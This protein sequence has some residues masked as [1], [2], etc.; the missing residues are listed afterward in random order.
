[1]E[2]ALVLASMRISMIIRIAI[3]G[4]MDMGDIADKVALPR[5]DDGAAV[6]CFCPPVAPADVQT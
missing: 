6:P 3:A 1:M 5:L 4:D 2:N